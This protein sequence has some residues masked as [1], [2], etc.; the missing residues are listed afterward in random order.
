MTHT[1][2][3]RLLAAGGRGEN[4]LALGDGLA[5]EADTLLGVED[6]AFPHE[7][8]DATGATV[9]LVESD[10][11]DDLGT[12]LP[13]RSISMMSFIYE[14]GTAYLRNVLISSIFSGSSSAKRSFRV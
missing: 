12:M 10:L 3:K 1:C 11:V 7:G 9:D 8:L 6:R 14:E 5:A 4:L 13:A 2:R